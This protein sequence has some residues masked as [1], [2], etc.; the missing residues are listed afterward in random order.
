MVVRP[1][2]IQ[3]AGFDLAH[4]L[5]RGDPRGRGAKILPLP[6]ARTPSTTGSGKGVRVGSGGGPRRTR[7]ARPCQPIPK[8][9]PFRNALVMGAVAL[10]GPPDRGRA[11]RGR[12]LRRRARRRQ[13]Q[14]SRPWGPLGRFW[15]L[16]GRSRGSLGAL[17]AVLGRSRGSPGAILGAIRIPS[18]PSS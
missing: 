5:C 17:L 9:P 8:Q 4:F 3:G 13:E 7:F 11:K 1:F 10:H 16:L 12:R 6:P 18:E 2:S 15:A 14:I